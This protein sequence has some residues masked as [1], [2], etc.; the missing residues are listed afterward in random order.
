[1]LKTIILLTSRFPYAPGEE[2]IESEIAYLANAADSVLILP[3]KLTPV[4]RPLPRNVEVISS[5][6]GEV[7]RHGEARKVLHRCASL[8]TES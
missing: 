4:Q 5:L 2:F 7:A 3:G 8:P 6:A 1:M